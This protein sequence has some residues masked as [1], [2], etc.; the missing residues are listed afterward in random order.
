M[1]TAQSPQSLPS[2]HREAASHPLA[3][4]VASRMRRLGTG[5]AAVALVGGLALGASVPAQASTTAPAAQAAQAATH[6][7]LAPADAAAKKPAVYW[8]WADSKAVK[9]KVIKSS[10]LSKRDD[11]LKVDHSQDVMG[12]V[13]GVTPDG[14]GFGTTDSDHFKPSLFTKF[15]PKKLAS[16][17]ARL[18]QLMQSGKSVYFVATKGQVY[19]INA[20]GQGKK[21]TKLGKIQS[22]IYSA[23]IG[24]GRVYWDKE[25][26][27][28]KGTTSWEVRSAPL[29]GGK[30]RLEARNAYG[31][32]LTDKGCW[33]R[34]SG[35]TRM[36]SLRFPSPAW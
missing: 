25:I 15:G 34:P 32:Q 10:G 29:K 13:A 31:V 12:G 27:P 35:P 7:A 14:M 28:A 18:D 36:T 11:V 6:S 2:L 16:G 33:R 24:N 21:A 30:S 5:T 8:H 19:R 4:S 20:P 9:P 3:A 23:V 1:S 17:L 26:T 22:D